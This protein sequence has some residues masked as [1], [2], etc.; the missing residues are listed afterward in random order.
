MIFSDIKNIIDTNRFDVFYREIKNKKP[1][2]KF[3]ISI[4]I[5]VRGR[6]DFVDVSLSHLKSAI[7]KT[8]LKINITIVEHSTNREYYEICKSYGIGYYWINS[9]ENKFNKCL[10]HNI[11]ALLNKNSNYFLFHDLDCLVYDNFFLNLIDNKESKKSECL[12]TFYNRRVLYLSEQQTRNLLNN[13]ISINDINL[14][15]LRV[16]NYGAPGGSIFVNKNLFFNVGGYDPE[17]FYG[18]SPEDIFFWNKIETL[19]KIHSVD[20]PKNELLH[21]HHEIQSNSDSL[22]LEEL[23]E[24]IKNSGDVVLN[25]IVKYKSEI[26]KKYI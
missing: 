19:E 11:G 9:L 23:Y 2:K 7:E 20:N 21:L 10:C 3:D 8:N 13:E 24:N 22:V 25:D 17:L 1:Y 15:E 18:W 26:L 14:E 4:I 12:Q 6:I 16:G 5:P